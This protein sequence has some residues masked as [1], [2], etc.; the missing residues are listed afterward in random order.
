MCT[1]MPKNVLE[2]RW[3]WVKPIA[4]DRTIRLK[5]AAKIFPHSQRTLERWVADYKKYGKLGL[6][7]R[8][9][10]PKSQPHETPIRIREMIVDIRKENRLCAKKIKWR[11]DE[12]GIDISERAIG[13]V[14]K[15]EGLTRR[16]RIRKIRYKY[17]KAEMALGELVEIDIKYV[18]RML[19]K[20][21]YYQFTA[22][23]SASRW[24][25]LKIY[26]NMGNI[27]AVDF[28]QELIAVAPFEIKAVKTDNGSCFTNRYTGFLKTTTAIPGLH[29]FDKFCQENNISHYLIDPG[30]PAQNG[31]VE[32]S[33]RTD[34]ESFYDRVQFSTLTELKY[35]LRLWNMY[36]NDL[37]H[38][39]LSGKSPNQMLK[40]SLNME[41]T[42]VCA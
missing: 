13:K 28:L 33:H 37:A 2:E 20:T 14:I 39:G 32:R 42:N 12:V 17:V 41:P 24:R 22:I 35:K 25:Y 5:E 18:P 29:I 7:P 34:Q 19:D 40:L 23:D 36:Y 9:T 16:Y 30:K 6:K 26:D 31:K 15:R 38:C 3:R 11:L 1:K 4:F 10:R 27:S 21:K 8:S